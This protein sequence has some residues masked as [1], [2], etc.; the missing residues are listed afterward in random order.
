MLKLINLTKRFISLTA[1]DNLN[2]EIPKGEIFGFL[3]PNGAGKTT[4]IKIMCGLLKPTEG[5]VIIDGFDIQKEPEAAKQRIGLIPDNPFI[6]PKLTGREFLHFI[7]N[8]Y[9]LPWHE[10]DEKIPELL[11]MFELTSWADD[12]IESYSHGMQQK[13]VMSGVLLHNPKIIFLDEPMVG[14]DPKSAKLVKEIFFNLSARGVTIFMSTHTLEIAEKMCHRIGI[15]Q[16]GKII[17]LGTKDTL[18]ENIAPDKNL[19][20]IFLELTGG[21][22]YADLL[23]YL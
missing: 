16:E 15:I 5:Q 17:A 20:D 19:E 1:V 2:L 9:K 4:T 8:L 23:K 11:A 21:T 13:L 7:G 10:Q 22:Q 6:Y 3:G 14:L 12:L 18:Q